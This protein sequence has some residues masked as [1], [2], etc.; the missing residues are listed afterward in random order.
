MRQFEIDDLVK[1]AAGDADAQFR[2]ERRQEVLKWNQENRKNAMALATPAWRDKKAIK[3][4]YQE[5]RRL[6]AETGIKHE[7][8]HIVPIM[9]KK[10]CGLHVEANLQILTKTENTR[11]YAKFPDMDISEQLERAGLQVIAGIRKLKAGLKV[12]KPVVAIDCHGAFY[13]I[14]SQYGQLA[15][16]SI[17]GS[18]TTPEAIVNFV[19]AQ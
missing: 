6:T 14:T 5:A 18:E 15:M 2:V 12:G 3:D 7:V 16:V 9:G 19:A 1:A 11:K 8:D 13:R 17:G 4:I 10:V